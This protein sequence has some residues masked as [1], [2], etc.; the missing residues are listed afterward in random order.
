MKRKDFSSIWSEGLIRLIS[1]LPGTG[2]LIKANSFS[3]GWGYTL[4]VCL[5]QCEKNYSE[6]ILTNGYTRY[7]HG[8]CS[9][10]SIVIVYY[11]FS[12]SE[13]YACKMISNQ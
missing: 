2:K 10:Y 3:L 11:D 12:K 1:S 6:H 13:F 5:V 4:N 9:E 8:K 7:F